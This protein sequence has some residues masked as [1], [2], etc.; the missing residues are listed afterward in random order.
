MSKEAGSQHSLVSSHFTTPDKEGRIDIFT[1]EIPPLS[2][3]MGCCLYT[4]ENQTCLYGLINSKKLWGAWPVFEFMT[5][6]SISP[7]AHLSLWE[8][9]QKISF[10]REVHLQITG[11]LSFWSCTFI[12]CVLWKM[13]HLKWD[14]VYCI[15]MFIPEMHAGFCLRHWLHFKYRLFSPDL[16]RR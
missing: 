2:H 3:F 10:G 4:F 1:L 11:S 12:G 13:A 16:R 5:P 15:I 6:K 7:T 14:T 8:L 9:E